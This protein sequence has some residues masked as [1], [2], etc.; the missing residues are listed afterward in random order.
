MVMTLHPGRLGSSWRTG[1]QARFQG[2]W[3]N[4][5][6]NRGDVGRVRGPVPGLAAMNIRGRSGEKV[7]WDQTE[8]S[9]CSFGTLGEGAKSVGEGAGGLCGWGARLWGHLKDTLDCGLAL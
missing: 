2:V 6:V 5:R 3:T 9:W 4:C 8:E 1:S 7:S